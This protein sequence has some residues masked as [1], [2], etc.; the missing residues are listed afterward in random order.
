MDSGQDR[1][2]DFR[3]AIGGTRPARLLVN[4]VLRIFHELVHEA[5][6]LLLADGLAS[7]LLLQLWAAVLESSEACKARHIHHSA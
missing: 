4:A 3:H 7:K 2:T 6:Q 1:D 5:H